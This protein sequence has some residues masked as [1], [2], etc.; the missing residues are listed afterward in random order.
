[1]D[2]T[3]P[4]ATVP[5][6]RLWQI[7]TYLIG[8]DG[9]RA[10]VTFRP[11]SRRWA[12]SSGRGGASRRPWRRSCWDNQHVQVGLSR[13][14]TGR[15][16]ERRPGRPRATSRRPFRITTNLQVVAD[17][18]GYRSARLPVGS[19]LQPS[20]TWMPGLVVV[21]ACSTVGTPRVADFQATCAVFQNIT[22]QKRSRPTLRRRTGPWATGGI[23]HEYK[24]ARQPPGARC[25]VGG[26]GLVR[27]RGPLTLFSSRCLRRRACRRRTPRGSSPCR[28]RRV[29]STRPCSR[30]RRG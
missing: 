28:P 27:V 26:R 23:T 19:S 11:S 16:D 3:P 18:L 30:C 21:L 1:M 13:P 9:R 7:P 24:C 4:F 6:R 12:P 2:G 17:E 25:Q 22:T 20:L 14:S 29:P 10:A 5:C 15:G 8:D